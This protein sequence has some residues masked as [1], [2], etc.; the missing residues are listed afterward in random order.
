MWIQMASRFPRNK[1]RTC[2]ANPPFSRIF[3]ALA[4]GRP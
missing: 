2:L 4:A 1:R 3:R